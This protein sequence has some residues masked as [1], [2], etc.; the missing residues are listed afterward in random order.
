MTTLTNNTTKR[1]VTIRTRRDGEFDVCFNHLNE[2]YT[3]RCVMVKTYVKESFA[4]KK[5][6]KFLIGELY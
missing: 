3:S 4:I 2:G 5:A 6:N 1:E